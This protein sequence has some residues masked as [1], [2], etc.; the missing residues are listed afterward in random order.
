M[1][2]VFE[3]SKKDISQKGLRPGSLIYI[4]EQKVDKV[5]IRVIDYDEK[6][7]IEYEYESIEETF[8][9]KDNNS[10]S[11][12]NIDGLHDVEVLRKLGENFGIHNL[13]LEDILNTDF[14][15][16]YSRPLRNEF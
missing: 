8:S 2:N 1:N 13:V 5:R 9:F 7:L 14:P 16:F 15:D 3:A 10:V 12:I 4:G 6:N 11:W